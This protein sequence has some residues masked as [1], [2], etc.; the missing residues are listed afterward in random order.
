MRVEASA[1]AKLVLL[2]EYAVLEGA[3]AIV[4][5]VNRRVHVSIE[6][7]AG[8]HWRYR[9][10]LDG[11]AEVRVSFDG[12]VARLEPELSW[13]QAAVLTTQ[14]ALVALTGSHPHRLPACDVHI[15]SA[16]LHGSGGQHKLGLGSSAAVVVAL[17]AAVQAGAPTW[18]QRSGDADPAEAYA[19][20]LYV[21]DQLQG[22]RGSGI[23]VAA[24]FHG[25]V[26]EFRRAGGETT[27]LV[28]PP[29]VH[30]RVVW[31]G[32]STSTPAYLQQVERVRDEQ[33]GHY[34]ACSHA[35]AAAAAQGIEACRKQD[36]EGWMDAV[37]AAHAAMASLGRLCDLEIVSPAHAELASLAARCGA[38]YKPSGA[39][40][41]DVGLLFATSSAALGKTSDEMRSAGYRL[42]D[43]AIDVE[44]VRAERHEMRAP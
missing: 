44:G 26:L 14:I 2:G 28:L 36:A 42:L 6:P 37:Q 32:A 3:P 35:L 1:P 25:G 21:H 23:D 18:L 9:S 39:G 41:G 43:L 29:E 24:A 19:T 16:A 33:P 5:A 13:A 30:M 38:A 34:A 17:T 12:V 31:T 40:G 20:D 7:I 11:G 4:A 10:D 22:G 27:P 15:Q 8:T